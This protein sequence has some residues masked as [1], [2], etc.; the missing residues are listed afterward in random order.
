MTPLA[1]CHNGEGATPF[2]VLQNYYFFAIIV[3]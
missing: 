2:D 3:A 1:I